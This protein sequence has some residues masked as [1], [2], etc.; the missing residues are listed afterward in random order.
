MLH[1][2]HNYFNHIIQFLCKILMDTFF[3]SITRWLCIMHINYYMRLYILANSR[4][5]KLYEQLLIILHRWLSADE[6][7][8]FTVNPFIF[9]AV[10]LG[11]YYM[12]LMRIKIT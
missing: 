4:N 3:K 12:Q 2:N 6:S 5:E 9:S 11:I 1:H 7:L 8:N 10:S